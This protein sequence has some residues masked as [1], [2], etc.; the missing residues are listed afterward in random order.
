MANRLTLKKDTKSLE[1]T[2]LSVTHCIPTA[3]HCTAKAVRLYM[4]EQVPLCFLHSKF[5]AQ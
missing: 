1:S 4:H 2:V 3:V 5:S